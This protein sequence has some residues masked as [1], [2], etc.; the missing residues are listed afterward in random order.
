M[1][2]SL[3]TVCVGRFLIEVPHATKIIDEKYEIKGNPLEFTRMGLE[4]H[5]QFLVEREKALRADK[6][7]PFKKM[8]HVPK[9]QGAVFVYGGDGAPVSYGV[10]GYAWSKDLLGGIQ[11]K[12]NSLLSNAAEID[13]R[14]EAVSVDL[15]R[16]RN[17]RDND[18][19]TEDG[20]CVNGG[21]FAGRPSME[22][23]NAIIEYRLTQHTDVLVKISILG[24][25]ANLEP[26]LLQRNSAPLPLALKSQAHLIKTLRRGKHPVGPLQG[27]EVLDLFNSKGLG[28]HEFY[29]QVQ[30]KSF[31]LYEPAIS[32]TLITGIDTNGQEVKPSLTN[33][34]AI[35]LFDRIVKSIRLRPTTP[36]KSSDAGGPNDGNNPAMPTRLP[37]K[38]K[39]TSSSN[40]PQA[41]IWE[42]APDAPGITAH[43]RFIEA[44]QPMPYGVAQR[45]AK[46]I[47]GLLGGQDDEALEV[48]WT[49]IGYDQENS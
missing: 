48:V 35:E 4:K 25:G 9:A 30:G 26:T 18:I 32:F 5:K 47:G 8:A 28:R 29:W 11:L 2:S 39:I 7:E 42:C 43:R 44:G 45:P 38:S 37:L 10:E 16:F 17:R 41:G 13:K 31:S 21:F 40:C 23:E 22:N 1:N 6:D 27:E 14:I 24:N 33:Q 49:L 20:Y 12:L 15:A 19:P 3:M 46:G 34:Q 36:G